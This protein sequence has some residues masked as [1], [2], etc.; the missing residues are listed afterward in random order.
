ME[1]MRWLQ[2]TEHKDCTFEES[3]CSRCSHEHAT[4]DRELALALAGVGTGDIKHP[5]ADERSVRR[6]RK[7]GCRPARFSLISFGSRRL[8]QQL[9]VSVVSRRWGRQG[10][11]FFPQF[12]ESRLANIKREV[13]LRMRAE[14]IFR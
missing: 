3:P 6:P 8:P 13:P 2:R 12:W 7:A 9:T 5:L 1:V 4:F 14:I 11:A 10:R